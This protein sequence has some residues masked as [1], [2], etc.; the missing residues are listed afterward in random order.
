MKPA[1]SRPS[2][3]ENVTVCVGSRLSAA[4][5]TLTKNTVEPASGRRTCWAM[6]MFFSLLG[7]ERRPSCC[8]CASVIVLVGLLPPPPPIE[9]SACWML[10][11]A[12]PPEEVVA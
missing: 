9:E 8:A 4:A 1:H 5:P 12:S 10:A 3:A 11:V 7:E 2:A 6:R